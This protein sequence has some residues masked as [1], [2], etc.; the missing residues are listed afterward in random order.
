VASV[1]P[2]VAHGGVYG[3]M[4]ETGIGIAVAALFLTVWFR[5]RGHGDRPEAEMRDDDD[6]SAD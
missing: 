6:V 1:A 3:A 2:I 5:A 4:A